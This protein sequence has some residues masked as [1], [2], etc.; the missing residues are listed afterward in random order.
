MPIML[1]CLVVSR[2][3]VVTGNLAKITNAVVEK[4]K[5]PTDITSYIVSMLYVLIVYGCF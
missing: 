1:L 5:I 4:E 2:G 3:L